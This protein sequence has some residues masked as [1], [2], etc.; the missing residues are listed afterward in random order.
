MDCL[1]LWPDSR[2]VSSAAVH[3]QILLL[4]HD[5]LEEITVEQ[6]SEGLGN[7]PVHVD[8]FYSLFKENHDLQWEFFNQVHQHNAVKKTIEPYEPWSNFRCNYHSHSTN[9]ANES[10]EL[11]CHVSLMKL[12]STWPRPSAQI[13]YH[14]QDQTL[15]GTQVLYVEQVAT[16]L[17]IA[18][19][20]E[21]IDSIKRLILGKV[22]TWVVPKP[23]PGLHLLVI[24]RPKEF[25][26]P[27]LCMMIRICCIC[28]SI[29]GVWRSTFGRSSFSLEVV[30][31]IKEKA[32]V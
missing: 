3:V 25:L 5:V 31:V 2:E 8:E 20:P 21:C 22:L 18:T 1:F 10:Q 30:S 24:R 17:G 7:N 11:E 27:H 15:K 19:T 14:V 16:E 9:V 32:V 29:T 4:Y 13:Q 12:A 23:A 6:I 28:K 26:I